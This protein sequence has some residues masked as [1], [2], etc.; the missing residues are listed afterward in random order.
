MEAAENACAAGGKHVPQGYDFRL[1]FDR[2]GTRPRKRTG[3]PAA[4]ARRCSTTDTRRRAAAPWARPTSPT[5]H[6]NT[7]CRT[8]CPERQRLKPTGDSATNASRCSTTGIRTKADARLAKV[9][10]RKATTSCCRTS[11]R[12]DDRQAC[13]PGCLAEPANPLNR[14][15][16]SRAQSSPIL[17]IGC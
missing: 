7:C 17:S 13:L 15:G 6:S 16:E 9:T 10:S 12:G 2:P 11:V 4:T 3:E 1:P 14:L 8:T 5:T